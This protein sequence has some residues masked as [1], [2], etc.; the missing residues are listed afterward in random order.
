MLS[1]VVGNKVNHR[2]VEASL[3]EHGSDQE[4][5]RREPARHID[6]IALISRV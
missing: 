5:L 2:A 4:N 1:E 6:Q 3:P